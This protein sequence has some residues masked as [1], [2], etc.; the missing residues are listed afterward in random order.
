V[1]TLTSSPSQASSSSGGGSG[2]G[3]GGGRKRAKTGAIVGGLL[4]GLFF[5]GVLGAIFVVLVR[6]RK[7]GN[8]SSKLR[9]DPQATFVPPAM[10]AGVGKGGGRAE[11]GGDGKGGVV[12]EKEIMGEAQ[13]HGVGRDNLAMSAGEKGVEI[14]GRGVQAQGGGGRYGLRPEELDSQGRYV[15]ELHGD[16]RQGGGF[17]LQGTE[18]VR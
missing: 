18:V 15:G 12:D 10:G 4:G 17:E 13:R 9:V 7:Q 11:L 5:L 16:G 3:A 14:D 8:P 1:Q 6:R 2:A